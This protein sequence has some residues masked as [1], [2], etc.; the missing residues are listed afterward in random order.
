M[1]RNKMKLKGNTIIDPQRLPET[2]LEKKIE[3]QIH[4]WLDQRMQHT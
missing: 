3:W 1:T 2:K 4:N